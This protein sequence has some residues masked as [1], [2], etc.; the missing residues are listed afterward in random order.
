[1]LKELCVGQLVRCGPYS[2]EAEALRGWTA[3]LPNGHEQLNSDH[4]RLRQNTFIFSGCF[5]G[6]GSPTRNVF[7]FP[8]KKK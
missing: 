2:L 1:M 8:K 6:Y 4:P 5:S 3:I 7:E